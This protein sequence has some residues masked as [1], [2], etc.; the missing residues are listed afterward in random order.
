[1]SKLLDTLRE[2]QKAEKEMLDGIRAARERWIGTYGVILK[3]LL[4]GNAAEQAFVLGAAQLGLIGARRVL[5][6]VLESVDDLDA[7]VAGLQG[8][9]VQ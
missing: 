9:I 8:R 6:D 3:Q 2:H 7:N 1:M 4:S 5:A